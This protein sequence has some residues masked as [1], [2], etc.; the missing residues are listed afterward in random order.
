RRADPWRW[1]AL[2][3]TRGDAA[4]RR[5]GCPGPAGHDVAGT[6][7]LD[8]HLPF[9]PGEVGLA[10]AGAAGAEEDVQVRD[11]QPGPKDRE[12][13]RRLGWGVGSDPDGPQHLAE[14]ACPAP[15]VLAEELLQLGRGGVGSVAVL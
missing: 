7:V 11:W 9:G 5:A 3:S 1:S 14:F 10:E 6:F 15:A 13:Q 8:A 2:R 4:A 12:A